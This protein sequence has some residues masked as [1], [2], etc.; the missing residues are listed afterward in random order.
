MCSEVTGRA[1]EVDFGAREVRVDGRPVHLTRSEF[2]LLRAL[3][4]RPGVALSDRD[5]LKSMW[6][7]VWDADTTP[8]QVHVCRLRRKLGESGRRPVRIV[9]VQG[10]GYRFVPLSADVFAG[11]PSPERRGVR[12]VLPPHGALTAMFALDQSVLWLCV[13]AGLNARWGSVSQGVGQGVCA[14]R[15]DRVLGGDAWAVLS[16]GSELVW[17]A[18]L[19]SAEGGLAPA[20]AWGRPVVDASGSTVA[21]WVVWSALGTP[22]SS[23]DRVDSAAL[24]WSGV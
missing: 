2:L 6:A 3:A 21:V 23:V 14:S 15:V 12:P 16:S 7:G 13:G 22:R 10:F 18:Q 4:S 20:D 8:L 17:R 11:L 5:L 19:P 1:L 9:T 24:V